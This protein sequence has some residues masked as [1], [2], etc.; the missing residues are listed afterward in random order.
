MGERIAAELLAAASRLRRDLRGLRFGSPVSHVYDPLD[1]ARRG[2]ERYVRAFAN[3]PKRVLF[4]GMNPG[5]FGMAQTGVP[6]GDVPM[7]RGWL[8]IE[9]P[10]GRPEREHPKRPVLGFACPR[11]EVSGTRFWGSLAARF[12]EPE[13]FFAEHFVANYC[14]LAFIEAS[15][16]N[17]TPDKLPER[18][19]APLFRICDAHLVRVVRALEPEWVIGIGAFAEGRAKA[20]LE[21]VRIGRI[22]HPSPANPSA[23]K[24]WGGT[25]QRELAALGVWPAGRRKR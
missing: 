10:I 11:S 14:P 12:G 1:Y 8:R 9:A 23:Q 24:D 6:F 2:Y 13:R 18:E 4:V 15:G 22:T 21:D 17:R 5:P 7:V 3:A 25:L 19:R 16:R 20:A